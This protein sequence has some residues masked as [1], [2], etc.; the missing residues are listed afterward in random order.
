[1]SPDRACQRQHLLLAAR[2]QP[3]G[4]A[5]ERLEL[6]EDRDRVGGGDVC[7][8]E[9]LLRGERHED[10]ALLGDEPHPAARTAEEGCLRRDATEDDVAGDGGELAGEGEERCGFSRAVRPD[11]R[12]DLAGLDVEVEV[13]H[14]GHGAVPGGEAAALEQRTGGDAHEDSP[15]VSSLCSASSSSDVTA[16]SPRYAATTAGSLRTSAGVPSAILRPKSSTTM[17]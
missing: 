7:E 16:S 8:P 2:Q 6:R 3:R 14:D 9:V 1:V 4:A 5:H 10:R 11:E 13:A 17:R 15:A 12:D